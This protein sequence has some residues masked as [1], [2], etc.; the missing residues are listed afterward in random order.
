MTPIVLRQVG[1][2]VGSD[3]SLRRH[4]LKGDR[5][6]DF[7]LVIFSV[8]DVDA[9]ASHA[10]FVFFCGYKHRKGVTVNRQNKKKEEEEWTEETH[11]EHRE[12][13]NE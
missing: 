9:G 3:A 11:A 8:V 10:V 4:E 5:D 7:V 1:L 6:R 13:R 12:R 2:P